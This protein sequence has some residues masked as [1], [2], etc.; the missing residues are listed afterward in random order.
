MCITNFARLV[1][2]RMLPQSDMY[3]DLESPI[4][5]EI[6]LLKIIAEEGTIATVRQLPVDVF[7]CH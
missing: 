3:V 7:A 2:Y 1:S 4:L 6:V 5:I